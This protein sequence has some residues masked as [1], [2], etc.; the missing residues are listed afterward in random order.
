MRKN[1]VEL[2]RS[3]EDCDIDARAFGHVDH[4][5][6]AYEMLRNYDFLSASVKYSECINTI[7]TRAG[8]SQKFNTTITLAFLSVIA[9]RM[10]AT[11]HDTFD[12]FIEENQDLLSGNILAKWYTP[13]RL[14]SDLARTVFLMPDAAAEPQ[15]IDIQ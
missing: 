15:S 13:E 11:R 1:Y 5:G 14:R 8:A 4:V 12:A 6:V 9:E 7:A 3:F 10:D 2:A